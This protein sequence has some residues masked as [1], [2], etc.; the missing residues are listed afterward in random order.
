MEPNSTAI[1]AQV[2]DPTSEALTLVADS[3]VTDALV[4]QRAPAEIVESARGAAVALM[5][6]MSQK[7]DKV[8][9]GGEQYIESEDWQLI[10]NFYGAT[11]RIVEDQFVQYGDAQGWE[12][13]AELV[14]RDGRVLSRATAMCLNDEEKWSTRAKYEFVQE[15]KPEHAFFAHAT[16]EVDGKRYARRDENAPGSALIWEAPEGGGKERP[17]AIRLQTGEDKVPMFQLR[18]MAQTRAAAKAHRMVFGFVPVLAGYRPTPAEELPDAQTVPNTNETAPRTAQDANAPA[19]TSTATS[20]P[21]SPAKP[22]TRTITEPQANRLWALQRKS[23]HSPEDVA[24]LIKNLGFDDTLKIT[25]AAYEPICNW[26]EGKGE[27]PKV[28]AKS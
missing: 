26:L 24:E 15:I 16:I 27:K 21:A 1:D 20:K 12:A 17:R 6:V 2:V 23:P 11:A 8:I 19:A 10:G 14:S 7:K 4:I 9:M 13:I 3:G 22:D 18:S 28:E 5:S 25:R